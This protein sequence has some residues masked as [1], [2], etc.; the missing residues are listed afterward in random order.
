MAA[1]EPLQLLF[2]N[3][4]VYYGHDAAMLPQLK[5]ADLVILESRGWTEEQIADLRASD[6][7]VLG[8]I[9]TFAWPDWLGPVKWW[10]GGK[11]RD[12]SWKAWW[13]SLG[14][15]GW[16]RQVGKMWREIRPGLDG[17][18]FDNLDRLEQDAG[19]LKPF[20]NLL[21]EI[22]SEWPDS[23]LVGNRGFAHFR[24]LQR[25]LDGI[26]FENL[27]DRAFSAADRNWVREQL[28]QLQGI[29]VY[30]LD[31]ATRYD[32]AEAERLR[33]DFS[34]MSYWQAKD[35]GLQSL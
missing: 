3:F 2:M 8:Y 29:E 23:K 10:W 6:C 34:K 22:K 28:L 4:R 20:Q 18:F 17:L 9:S 30:A 13:L 16:R 31:Y 11:E 15:F 12:E 14:S 32:A 26:L 25:H 19:S 7:K 1:V 33:T 24:Q 27:T 21:A 35:E 5:E